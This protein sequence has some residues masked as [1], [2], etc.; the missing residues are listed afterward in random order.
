[1]IST[2]QAE[3]MVTEK[4]EREAKA[5]QPE[6][7]DK[8][9]I[10]QPTPEPEKKP[11]PEPEPE[12][13]DEPKAEKPEAK[14]EE[15]QQP[16]PEKK[17]EPKDKPEKDKDRSDKKLPP[18]KRYSHDERVA[19]AFSIEKQKREKLKGRVKELEAELAKYKGLKPEDFGNNIEDYTN[20]RLDEQKKLDEVENARKE[21]E[22]SEAQ[23]M[24]LETERRVNLSFP[25]ETERNDYNELIRTCG[26]EFYAALKKNDKEGVVLDYLNHVEQY[27]IVLRELMTNMESLRRVFR[28]K[29]PYIRRLDLHQFATELLEGKRAPQP[30]AAPAPAAPEQKPSGHP[31]QTNQP[32]LKPLPVIGKQVTATAKPSE[33]VHDRAYW[34]DYLR[35]HP[36]G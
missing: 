3:Q 9:E 7:S 25:D 20:Y 11:E 18:S 13:K 30:A 6:P 12:K 27:P 16:E 31:E 28:S 17:D 19:H 10:E 5:A 32:A 36:H 33:P 8:P 22:R 4:M 15:N 24:E 21:I 35:K 14:P 1:M 23:E 2:E 29:D 34:N 26:P